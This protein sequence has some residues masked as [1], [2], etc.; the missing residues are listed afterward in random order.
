MDD[1][2][3]DMISK[4]IDEMDSGL[5]D[6]IKR[7]TGFVKNGKP[8]IAVICSDNRLRMRMEQ[9]FTVRT[10]IEAVV[11]YTN[12]ENDNIYDLMLTDAVIAVTN[13]LQVAPKGLYD[14][15]NKL[16]GVSKEVYVLLGGWGAMPRTPEMLASKTK[17]VP[18]DFP[19]AKIVSVSSFYDEKLD[20]FLLEQDAADKYTE[21]ILAS[22]ERQHSAQSEAL[23][24]WLK[25]S[26]AN[27]YA[28]CNKQIDKE[29]LMTINSSRILA[30]KQ[31]RFELEFT[32]SAVSMQN[33]VE[34]AS[35][36]MSGITIAELEDACGDLESMVRGDVHSAQRS[37]KR[38]LAQLLLKALDS[39]LGDT[40]NPVKIKSRA[41]ADSC[42]SAM[43]II[44]SEMQN[45]IY[46]SSELKENFSKE[47]ADTADLDKIVNK[48]D[49]IARLTLDRARANPRSCKIL[50]LYAEARFNRKGARCGQR[51]S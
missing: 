33:L 4:H 46:I 32:H 13:A 27:F 1:I 35:K 5:V 21:H 50:S 43:E 14:T 9:I 2:R 10:D 11:C 20:G 17:K 34:L 25:K 31:G 41:T 16:S 51:Y 29:K 12:S 28:D 24:L 44:N 15:L 39:C 49:E 42:I 8:R 45:A 36:R 7:F 23:Y 47:V 38:A 30:A 19:F 26:I 48:Y 37:T 18:D 3:L 22:F 6:M 40:D